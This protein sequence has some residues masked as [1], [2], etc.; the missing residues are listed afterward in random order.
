VKNNL[1]EISFDEV[2]GE[3]GTTYTVFRNTLRPRYGLVIFDI[4][5]GYLFL[6]LTVACAIVLLHYFNVSKWIIIP[7]AGLVI[8]YIAA[9]LAL[10]IHEAGHFNIDSDKK[11]ND[12]LSTIFLCLLFGI[13]LKSYRKIHW[14][15]HVHLG[16]PLDTETSYFNA[17]TPVFILETFT[18]IHL[19]RTI[20][21]KVNHSVLTK[22][23]TR[24][25]RIMLFAGILVHLLILSGFFF[26]G[27]WPLAVSWV[28]GFGIFFPFFATLRQILEHRDELAS[29]KTN[30]N[31]QAHGKVTRLFAHNLVSGSFGSAGFTRH[32]IHHWDP[33]ISYTRLKDIERFLDQCEKT[34]V[35]IRESKTR[36][37]SVFQK[38]LASS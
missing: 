3:N 24:D 38:L 35:I 2:V 20:S 5:K 31:Q 6:M 27:F 30:F 33:L 34:K 11:K 7:V 16:S 1:E 37:L 36:Y 19:L 9:Y 8:G 10:F 12:R 23:Q 17:P 26:F 21:K 4:V 15:H 25:S 14:Q 22:E 29:R 32:M 18:G 13:S 28:I